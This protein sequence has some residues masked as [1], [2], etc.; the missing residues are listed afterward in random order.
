MKNKKMRALNHAHKSKIFALANILFACIVMF[1][2]SAVLNDLMAIVATGGVSFA[3]M[4]S[5]GNIE[6][7]SDRFTAGAQMSS[8]IWLIHV[9][10][11]VDDTV[12]FPQANLNRQIGTIPMKAGQYM[13]YFIGIDD[14]P[15]DTS[16]GTKGD[17]TTNVTNTLSF[18]MGGNGDK[19]LDFIEQYAGGRFLVIYQI[20]SDSDYYIMGTP[21]K[22]MIL[23]SFER[24][25]DKDSRSITFTFQSTGFNQPYHY[26]GDLV[27]EAPAVIGTD[28]TSL[29]IQPSRNTY[30]TPTDNTASTTLDDVI[31]LANSDKGRLI[32]IVG[33]GGEYPLLIDHNDVFILA[34]EQQWKGTTGSRISFRVLDTDTLVEVDRTQM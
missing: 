28:A 24:K 6:K 31:G 12:P 14:T 32:E 7:V 17:I 13:H 11:Q 2:F 33:K 10:S 4:G 5:I 9:D 26:R 25:N 34:D 1:V 30:A 20:C 23:Q 18:I 27:R 8:K 29:T 16:T 15:S 21:C 3:S 22:P 19:L